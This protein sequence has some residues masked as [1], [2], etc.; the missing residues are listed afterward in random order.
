MT[1]QVSPKHSKKP[2]PHQTNHSTRTTSAEKLRKKEKKSHEIA[3]AHFRVPEESTRKSVDMTPKKP[4]KT[5]TKSSVESSASSNYSEQSESKTRSTRIVHMVTPFDQAR[6]ESL[7]LFEE[8]SRVHIRLMRKQVERKPMTEAEKANLQ[9]AVLDFYRNAHQLH[10]DENI[11]VDRFDY[12]TP[13]FAPGEGVNFF[14]P[15]SRDSLRGFDFK[16]F[17]LFLNDKIGLVDGQ[18]HIENNARKMAQLMALGRRATSAFIEKWKPVTYSTDPTANRKAEYD[19]NLERLQDHLSALITFDKRIRSICKNL[20]GKKE[21]LRST[22]AQA[23][24]DAV[25][26]KCK[27]KEEA[28]SVPGLTVEAIRLHYQPYELDSIMSK[29]AHE[30]FMCF[31]HFH[32]SAAL[33][34]EKAGEKWGEDFKTSP[35]PNQMTE[36]KRA[37]YGPKKQKGIVSFLDDKGNVLLGPF[38][39][40]SRELR[41]SHLNQYVINCER[42]VGERL[43]N[44]AELMQKLCDL[45][46]EETNLEAPPVGIEKRLK[47]QKRI[48]DHITKMCED[49]PRFMAF[50]GSIVQ[51]INA[52]NA[53]RGDQQ[54]P[55]VTI[56]KVLEMQSR[57]ME[58][59]R[60]PYQKFVIGPTTNLRSAFKMIYPKARLS[61]FLR[62][63]PKPGVINEEPIKQDE[64]ELKEGYEANRIDIT[65]MEHSLDVVY[66]TPSL[67][68]A[69]GTDA[70]YTLIQKMSLK[71]HLGEDRKTV[72]VEFLYE[73][74]EG[75]S[76]ED[77][78]LLDKSKDRVD[79]VLRALD[80]P[81]L[82][83][84]VPIKD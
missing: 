24:C 10:F 52:W 27:T 62:D 18:K 4:A 66:H 29:K 79:V 7:R 19:A 72:E 76:S 78:A 48:M 17:N 55:E 59:Y 82:Q 23:F 11:P 50:I 80:Y 57:L 69:K 22:S 28:G 16:S 21:T 2:H 36:W 42:V 8:V 44:D 77:M 20:E 35:M 32:P 56:A 81:K 51:K 73:V 13:F 41:E 68:C 74:P 53:T 39:M 61:D 49:I 15:K 34:K 3:T 26:A 65:F 60:A 12:S 25:R 43:Y 64:N 14:S 30:I 63:L 33:L 71:T 1:L 38:E 84:R 5:S 45:I 37:I 46:E 70:T 6:E 40:P 31:Q 58:F 54:G 67:I 47:A 75:L 83:Q 9:Q